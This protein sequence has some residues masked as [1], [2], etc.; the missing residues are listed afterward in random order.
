MKA[1]KVT[2]DNPPV[3]I[4]CA[5]DGAF[6]RHIPTLMNSVRANTTDSIELGIFSTAWRKSDQENL[7]AALPDINISFIELSAETLKG[8]RVKMVLSP[9]AY[10][11]VFMADLVE[12][13]KFIYLDVDM[14]A[15]ADLSELYRVPLGNAPAAAV[16]HGK[17]LN[18]GLLV[19]NAKSWRD[20]HLA[21]QL[22][23]YARQNNP[24]EADQESIENVIGPELIRLDESWNTLVD[25]LWGS[26][27]LDNHTYLE[28]A[29]ILHF[30]T[31]FKPWNS[32]QFL[33][34]QP[35]V[36]EWKKYKKRSGLS[37]DW[38]HEAKT[39]FWQAGV[40]I[41]HLLKS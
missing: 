10:A 15:R 28:T 29:K 39:L 7:V 22:L 12:W 38:K 32:G 35:Y 19:V 4:A 5:A 11:R 2:L 26:H 18:S 34:P 16:F 3:R 27:M 24:K 30:I 25:P 37:I 31:G 6:L 41:R 17:K 21:F 23:E 33:L 9:M 20:R 14:I 8:L 36:W 40:L 13:D 1:A